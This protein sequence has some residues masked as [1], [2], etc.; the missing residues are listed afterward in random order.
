M[1]RDDLSAAILVGG[2]SRRMGTNKALLRLEPNGPSVVESVARTL[3]SITGDVLLVGSGVV[4]CDLS[5]LRQ[6][7][8]EYPNTGALGGICTALRQSASPHVLVVACDMP[9]LSLD[10]LRYMISLPRTYD[11]LVPLLDELHP[12]HAIYARTCLPLIEA[13][14]RAGLYR[15]TGWFSRANVQTIPAATMM[16]MNPA[17]SSCFNM[18][19]PDDFA[20]AKRLANVEAR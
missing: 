5:G 2:Q 10:F 19:T 8:D 16:A 18:N 6:V 17:M 4:D 1:A 9:F 7:E 14:L 12:L 15:V 11:V 20:E 3:R 13:E